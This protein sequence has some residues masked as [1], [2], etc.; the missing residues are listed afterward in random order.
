MCVRACV[1]ACVRACVCVCYELFLSQRR[2][3]ASISKE[4]EYGVTGRIHTLFR[5]SPNAHCDTKFYDE[6]DIFS[7]FLES[8]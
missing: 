7:F 3:V 2:G 4:G 1:C 6:F 8:A 5:V